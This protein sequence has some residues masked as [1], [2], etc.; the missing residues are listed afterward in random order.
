MTDHS[1]IHIEVLLS[2]IVGESSAIRVRRPLT[3]STL[4][5]FEN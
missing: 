3:Y 4:S 2:V 1:S 5:D